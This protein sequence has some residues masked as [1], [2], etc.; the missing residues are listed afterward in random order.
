MFDAAIRDAIA[1]V[2]RQLTQVL[3][4]VV[5]FARTNPLTVVLI[6]AGLLIGGGGNAQRPASGRW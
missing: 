2:P 5:E 3:P 6:V 4:V 1:D